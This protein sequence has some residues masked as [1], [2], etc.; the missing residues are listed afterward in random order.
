MA[1]FP[2]VAAAVVVMVSSSGLTSMAQP[3]VRRVELRVW[4]MERFTVSVLKCRV[5][6]SNY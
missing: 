1:C 5:I 4:T 3:Q 6:W 2:R